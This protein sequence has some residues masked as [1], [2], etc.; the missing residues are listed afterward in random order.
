MQV[1]HT[2]THAGKVQKHLLAN[3]RQYRYK[4]LEGAILIHLLQLVHVVPEDP[5]D[6][7]TAAEVGGGGTVKGKG[8]TTCYV[9]TLA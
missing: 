1:H 8:M 2:C 5:S 4:M 7:L 6:H 9:I 3:T